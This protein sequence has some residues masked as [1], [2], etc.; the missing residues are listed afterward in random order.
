MFISVVVCTYKSPELLRKSLTS[1][2]G[3]NYSEKAYEVIVVDD[4]LLDETAD[5]CEGFNVRLVRQNDL[6]LAAAR[7]AGIKAAYGDIIA[8]TDEDAQV[9]EEWLQVIHDHFEKDPNLACLGGLEEPAKGVPYFGKCRCYQDAFFRT[10]LYFLK[11]PCL[12]VRGCNMAFRKKALLEV[13]LFNPAFRGLED[14]EL[15]Q[16]IAKRDMKVV[17]DPHQVVFH[18][19]EGFR[20]SLIEKQLGRRPQNNWRYSAVVYGKSYKV[21]YLTIALFAVAFF[22]LIL[23]AKLFLICFFL[24][25][26]VLLVVSTAVAII[27]PRDVR[28]IPGIFVEIA[29]Q[30]WLTTAK[31]IYTS[32]IRQTV[33]SSY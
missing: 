11:N 5:V 27:F 17:F 6:G 7:N 3:T 10:H 9:S 13:G 26:A 31:G 4:G 8:F 21:H 29:F 16:R 2:I 28:Y 12:K 20:K 30:I 14:G 23:D 33:V 24:A 25:S 1:I 22:L 32:F 18:R 19:I 15:I